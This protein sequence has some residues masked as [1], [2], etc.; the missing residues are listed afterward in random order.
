MNTLRVP[1]I[2]ASPPAPDSDCT[3]F[4]SPQ[5]VFLVKMSGPLSRPVFE[6]SLA[7]SSYV[8]AKNWAPGVTGPEPS[9]RTVRVRA[10]ASEK[11]NEV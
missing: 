7:S 10:R 8:C 9:A 1:V 6:A 2:T 5:P 11:I 4:P 3:A